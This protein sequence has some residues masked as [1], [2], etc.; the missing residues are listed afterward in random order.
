MIE[1]TD[2]SSNK[3]DILDF[4]NFLYLPDIT[5]LVVENILVLFYHS[6]HNDQEKIDLYTLI[7]FYILT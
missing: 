3:Y 4:S 1:I 6:S 7:N 2:V 5:Q